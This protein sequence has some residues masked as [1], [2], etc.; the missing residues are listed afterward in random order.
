M[1][2]DDIVKQ[3]REEL[4]NKPVLPEP[5]TSGK[6][7]KRAIAKKGVSLIAELKKASPSAGN[8][9]EFDVAELL[10]L[11]NQY[12]DAVS[13]VTDRKFFCGDVK[14]IPTLK[15]HLPV[16]RKD[17][18]I[19]SYQILESRHYGADAILLIAAILTED[20]IREFK[21][22]ASKYCMDTIV[23]VHNEAEL[24]KALNAGAEIIGINN[25]NLKTFEVNLKTT[26][27]LAKLIPEDKI[28]VS[29]SGIRTKQD[30]PNVNAVLVGTS[31]I[32]AAD[33][34]AKLLELA[35]TK[36]KI[37][38][39]TNEKDALASKDADYLG[40]NFYKKSPRYIEPEKAKEI[41]T[42][43]PNIIVGVFV[44]ESQDEILRTVELCNL[45][46]IQLH[47]DESAEFCSEL[48]KKTDKPLIKAFRVKD[49]IP[50]TSAYQVDYILLDAYSEKEYGGT[51]SQF[52]YKLIEKID[53]PLF[54]SGGLNP[55]NIDRA[56][57]SVK[58]FAIDIC[59]GV[60]SEPGK[61]D[62][63]KIKLLINEV[64]R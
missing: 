23:E 6:D 34:K 16:L 3:K 5:Q 17:F 9:R 12:A 27:K 24:K 56:I 48:K 62:E 38:G 20:Q 11:Y 47:G 25:R 37:C 31:I 30:I 21:V 19:D 51:G 63:T 4:K 60:E 61:K 54:L 28:V 10:Q 14:L 36:L 22:L 50:D 40:F 52:D 35:G 57:E 45:D 53:K 26:E 59:S 33:R 13:V 46:A 1:I 7:F 32:N 15:T 8:L 44:N 55:S 2:L 29:E 42:K 58:P 49:A 41:I 39:I 18:I 64:K 43:L